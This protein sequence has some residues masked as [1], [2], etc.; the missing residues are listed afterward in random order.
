MLEIFKKRHSFVCNED[1]ATELGTWFV[2]MNVTVEDIFEIKPALGSDEPM[3]Y[4]L[5]RFSFIDWLCYLL[6]FGRN[7]NWMRV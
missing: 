6:E 4:F 1:D 5:A 7:E 3:W 2:M